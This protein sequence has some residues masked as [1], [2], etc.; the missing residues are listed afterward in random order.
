MTDTLVIHGPNTKGMTLADRNRSLLGWGSQTQAFREF[1]AEEERDNTDIKRPM[2]GCA[3]TP[4]R[5]YP[6]EDE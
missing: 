6:R 4:W 5:L 3:V 2:I 1:I